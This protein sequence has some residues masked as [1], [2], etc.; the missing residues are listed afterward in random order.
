VMLLS[1]W[2]AIGSL[3]LTPP[4]TLWLHSMGC[5]FCPYSI[6][7]SFPIKFGWN[8]MYI[9]VEVVGTLLD[10]KLLPGHNWTYVMIILISSIFWVNYFPHEGKI[11]TI[12]QFYFSHL[13]LAAWLRSILLLIDSSQVV[14]KSI[15][16]SMYSS[17]MGN[18]NTVTPI[19]YI[20]STLDI[21]ISSIPI[22]GVHDF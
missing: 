2:K 5:S 6:V 12:D 22:F 4:P 15:D 3:E 20:R 16:I 10:Y 8:T 14:T 9:E 1:C 7:S 13:D 11:M 18:F 17:L 19:S 21:S